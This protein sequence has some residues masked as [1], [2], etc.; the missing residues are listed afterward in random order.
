MSL[1]S[2]SLLHAVFEST[3]DGIL[4][5]DGEG[6]VIQSNRRFQE[7]WKIPDSIVQT[8]DDQKLLNFILDQLLDPPKFI[9]RVQSLYRNDEAFSDDTVEFKDG[10]IFDRHSRPL[11]SG[12]VTVGRLWRF[13]DITTEKKS[14]E[15]FS[16]I[17]ELSPDIISILSPGGELIYNS[18][19][20]VRIHGYS[21]EEMIGKNTF[22]FIHPD[23]QSQCAFAMEAL[24]SDPSKIATV[25]Y[26]Y[27]NKNGHYD[28]MEATASNQIA[29]PFINGFVVIS[30][31]IGERKKLEHELNDALKTK[32]DFISII[33][34]ELKT[35]VTSIK[36]Q[37][38][39]L[40]RSGKTLH[41]GADS[42]RSEN[43]PALISQ[44]NSLDRLIDD[45]LQVS[46][47][48]NG[49]LNFEMKEEN[50]GRL[51][52]ESEEYLR[53]LLSSAGCRL[54]T[55]I[56][57]E[58][59]VLCDKLRI[60]QVVLNLI[61]NIV[62]YAP[63]KP[64]KIKLK[65]EDGMAKISVT[66]N[67]PGIPEEKQSEIFNLFSRGADAHHAGGLGVGLFISK[68]ILDHHK[69]TIDVKSSAGKGSEFVIRLPLHS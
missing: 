20:S 43:F 67:G 15:M 51:F 50:L 37:L 34:H 4:I 29:N 35:P 54:D 27:R 1:D 40:Q 31:E 41:S 21:P 12:G 28:W 3:V 8:R 61:S 24:R 17:A 68:S 45:L 47:I 63:G 65:A 22:E 10:R 42:T 64:V 33:T 11:K 52:K 44:V 30:R 48:R 6:K 36:L 23:D 60:E 2:L 56:D 13:R 53:N 57:G 39:I 69:G 25:Q 18:P 38:Q 9:S 32:D 66:D 19:A 55:D 59:I 26:R 49:K 16:A 46:R 14:L 62:K 7:L 5:V 58:V